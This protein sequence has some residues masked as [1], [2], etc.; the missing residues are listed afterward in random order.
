MRFIIRE[1]DSEKLLAAGLYSYQHKNQPTG[2]TEEWRLTE[3]LGQ[4]R[5][6]RTDI[7]ERESRSN[8]ST[9]FHL[10]INRDN[11]PQRLKIRFFSPLSLGW[12]D[13]MISEDG[14][15]LSQDFGHGR[16][17]TEA[18]FDASV[19]FLYSSV[20]WL[21]MWL[22]HQRIQPA[23]KLYYLSKNDQFEL[24]ESSSSF[25]QQKGKPVRVGGRSITTNHYSLKLSDKKQDFWIDSFG[26]TVKAALSEDLTVEETRYIRQM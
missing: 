9:L 7:D 24:I 14:I 3:V 8:Q 12:A 25:Q 2:V 26:L 15:I 23:S 10:I 20:T 13:I 5:I 4:Y 1:Q 6:L 22:S 16:I 11:Q 21:G 19:G 18:E 17:E